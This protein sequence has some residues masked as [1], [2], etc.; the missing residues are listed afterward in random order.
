MKSF[1]AINLRSPISPT[2]LAAN[3]NDWNPTGLANAS[4]IRMDASGAIDL[5]GISVASIVTG[6]G[7][8]RVLLLCHIGASN[9]VTLK[10]QSASSSAAHRFTCANATDVTLRPL[11]SVW[12]WYDLT[13]TT[14]RVVGS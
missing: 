3:T 10:H 4:V 8:G 11:G 6:L 2:A 7:D 1:K 5:T 14:W 12:L 9:N 13:S